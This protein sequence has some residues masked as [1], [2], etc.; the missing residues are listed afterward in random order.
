[1]KL[2]R[3]S[4]RSR[5]IE[6]LPLIDLMFLLLAAFVYA[7]QSMSVHRVLPVELPDA[8]HGEI[9]RRGH[10]TIT[11]TPGGAVYLEGEAVPVADLAARVRARLAAEPKLRIS[12]E[13]DRRA[14]CGR[15]VG[16]LDALRA[17][18]AKGVRLSVSKPAGD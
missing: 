12:V 10:L 1:V 14:A 16:V 6:L 3:S 2:K 18:G 17:A 8:R 4:P 13:A 9:D 7:T 5:R 15:A 11:V